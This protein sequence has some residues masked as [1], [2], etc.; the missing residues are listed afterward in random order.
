MKRC[1]GERGVARGWSERA[2]CSPGSS[3]ACSATVGN[4]AGDERLL[5]DARLT[6]TEMQPTAAMHGSPARFLTRGSR[7]RRGA[8]S[9][10]LRSE[11]EGSKRRQSNGGRRRSA[12]QGSRARREMGGA[13]EGEGERQG[14]GGLVASL[15]TERGPVGWGTAA[16]SAGRHG[17]RPCRHSGGRGRPFCRNPPY[18][19]YFIYKKVHIKLWRFKRDTRTFL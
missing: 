17:R 19:F 2:R 8:A 6:R 9:Y 4:D 15:T 14:T 1:E 12:K 5:D 11:R 3:V 16:W 7:E 18:L 13:G 10:R